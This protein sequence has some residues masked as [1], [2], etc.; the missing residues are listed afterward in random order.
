M[1]ALTGPGIGAT[2][3]RESGDIDVHI[4]THSA[5]GGKLALPRL[6][7]ALSA[8]RRLAGFGFALVG[9]PL[10]TWLLFVSRTDESITRDVLS[11]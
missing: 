5:A 9:G 3:I 1:A 7:G 2:V 6:G 11:Y 4:V 8:R 10:A